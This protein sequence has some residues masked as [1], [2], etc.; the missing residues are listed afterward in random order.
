MKVFMIGGGGFRGCR[1]ALWLLE[2]KTLAGP[3]SRPSVNSRIKLRPYHA[4]R[5]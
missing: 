3:D 2:C 4:G 1:L 5:T